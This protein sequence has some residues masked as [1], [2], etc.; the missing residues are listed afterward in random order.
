MH[1]PKTSA[2]TPGVRASTPGHAAYPHQATEAQ[3]IQIGEKVL[4]GQGQG[5]WPVCGPKAG[6]GAD[7]AKPS[8]PDASAR[9]TRVPGPST[10]AGTTAPSRARRS[11]ATRGGRRWPGTG[12]ATASPPSAATTRR[13]ARSA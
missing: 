5:A 9:T 7:H 12:T 13:P 1:V 8:S 3:Q 6:L 11:S 4:A 10:R 2:P